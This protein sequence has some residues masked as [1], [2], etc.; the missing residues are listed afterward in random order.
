MKSKHLKG[1]ELVLDS[2]YRV[3][4][5]REMRA[6]VKVDGKTAVFPFSS[7]FNGWRN[8]Y[9]SQT[10]LGFS[11]PNGA[12]ENRVYFCVGEKLRTEKP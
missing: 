4:K 9:M 10:A 12:P 11:S 2:I 1:N 3:S 6:R 7:S 8:T 5:G